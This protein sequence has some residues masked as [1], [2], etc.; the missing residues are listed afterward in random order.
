M[1][2][3]AVG[4]SV[5]CAWNVPA[6]SVWTL[7][8]KNTS[9]PVGESAWIETVAPGTAL[10]VESVTWPW[11]VTVP[12]DWY[13]DWSVVILRN[14]F[15]AVETV[16]REVEYVAADISRVIWFVNSWPLTRATTVTM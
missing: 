1:P 11:T 3:V 14:R 5:N 12:L 6:A 8:V 2:S 16:T 4:G 10:P 7:L 13:W 9:T 15:A